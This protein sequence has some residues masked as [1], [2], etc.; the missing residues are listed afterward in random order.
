MIM[1][2]ARKGVLRA[3]P[4]DPPLAIVRHWLIEAPKLLAAFRR[5]HVLEMPVETNRPKQDIKVA[6]PAITAPMLEVLT[7]DP[8]IFST[9]INTE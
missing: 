4:I 9:G 2:P 8:V 7:I 6:A 5:S 3:S 1:P